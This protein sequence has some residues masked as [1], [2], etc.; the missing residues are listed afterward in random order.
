[1]IRRQFL[2][3]CIAAGLPGG[4]AMSPLRTLAQQP[5]APGR[6]KLQTAQPGA[7]PQGAGQPP[8][9]QRPAANLV[10]VQLPKELE[11]VLIAWEHKSGEITRLRGAIEKITYDMVYFVEKRAEG[12]L[13]YQSPDQGRID[14]RPSS[15]SDPSDKKG[16]KGETYTVQLEGRQRWICNGNMIY[17]IYDDEKL[18]DQVQIPAHQQ[19]KN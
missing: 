4:I 1:M 17:I 15:K 3:W 10:Q 14:F 7:Q 19:G 5:Q 2:T 16:P 11:D 8:R 13:W 9:E 12:N 18:F 6:A